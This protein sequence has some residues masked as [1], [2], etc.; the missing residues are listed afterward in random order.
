MTTRSAGRATT[1]PRGGRTGGWTSKG[2]GRTR[3]RSGDQGNGE[4]DG[5]GGQVGAQGNEVN[6]G[7][8][9]VPNFST[10]IAH[11]LQNLLLTILAQ[12]GNQGNNQGNP[13]NQNSDAVND[14]IQGDVRNVIVNSNRKGCTYK[15]FLAYN[16]KEYDGKGGAIVY[17]RWIEKIEV[18]VATESVTI[19][20][21]VQKAR[22][23]TNE[24]V[25]NGS[26][27][28]NPEKRGNGE[29]PNR[30]MNARDENKKNRTRNT[31]ATTTN[32]VRREYNGTIPK[33][34]SCNLHHP[35]EMPCRACFNCG[36]PVHMAKF[37]RVASRMMNLVN[38]RNPTAAPGACYECR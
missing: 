19:Q 6:D 11:Q 35:P 31:F 7:V 20:R 28:K 13:R 1:T 18:V 22:T 15:D 37:Y 10:I 34:V 8:N 14:N 32:P 16:P 30:D 33:C 29:E 21:V 24:A 25:R 2:G 4:V 26:L 17:T 3:G 12:V 23:L 5:Q 9:G 38:A 27:K 36:R